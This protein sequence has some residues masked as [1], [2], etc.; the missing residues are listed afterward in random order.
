MSTIKQIVNYF[1]KHKKFIILKKRIPQH[2][3][4]IL[5]VGTPLVDIIVNVGHDF[6]EKYKLSPDSATRCTPELEGI[7]KHVQVLEIFV[8]DY[9]KDILLYNPILQPGG[10]VTNTARVFQWVSKRTY[11]ITFFGAVG[12]DQF[13]NIIKDTFKVEEIHSHLVEMKGH[14]TGT[15][16]VLLTEDYRSLVCNMGASKLLSVECLDEALWKH[17]NKASYL[18]MSAFLLGPVN[19]GTI[20][21][22]VNYFHK[23]KKF[24]FLNLAAPFLCD[25]YPNEVLFLFEHADMVFGNESEY[26]A[27]SNISKVQKSDLKDLLPDLNKRFSNKPLRTLVMT[28]GNKS[29]LVL[30]NGLLEQ[31]ET[32]QLEEEKIVDTNGAGDAFVGGYL[33]QYMR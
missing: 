6:L 17:V 18:Y 5:F 22:L 32:D 27:L 10:S 7:F 21:E 28:R 31:F 11:P 25:K 20:K 30:N 14:K 19:M 13:G 1:H 33:T 2:S 24:I 4:M 9:F 16:A 8:H 23:H 26:R 29:V 15:C 12:D 3:A